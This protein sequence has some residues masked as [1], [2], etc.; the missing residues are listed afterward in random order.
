MN[1]YLFRHGIALDVGE[2]GITSD[3]QRPLSDEGMEK[4]ANIAKALK[5]LKCNPARII[6]SP[7]IRARQTA[8]IAAGI[9]CPDTTPEPNDIMGPNAS[10]GET[11]DYL[12]KQ[13]LKDIMLVGHNP[14]MEMLASYLISG[15]D[16][17]EIRLKKTSICRIA[18]D[19]KVRP[20]TGIMEWL[21]QP[22]QLL[23]L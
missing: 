18:F 5:K 12:A 13:G 2:N 23:G 3:A 19:E 14:H 15:S 7:L 21:M 16:N 22:A 20:G 8:N 9:L 6:S 11:T 4:T 10:P 17:I 1:V